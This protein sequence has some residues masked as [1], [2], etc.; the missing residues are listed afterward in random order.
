M[1]F[2]VM[3]RPFH[4]PAAPGRDGWPGSVQYRVGAGGSSDLSGHAVAGGE[5]IIPIEPARAGVNAV[6]VR[7]P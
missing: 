2:R 7:V 6:E 3:C 5:E 4:W 1:A